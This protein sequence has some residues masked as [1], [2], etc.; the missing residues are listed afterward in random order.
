MSKLTF[1]ADDELV[2]RLEAEFD[3]SKSQVL[4]EALQEYIDRHGE[5]VGRAG[6]ADPGSERLDDLLAERVDR[7]VAERVDAHG[8]AQDINV[9]ISVDG[10]AAES[11]TAESHTEAA[12]PREETPT[13]TDTRSTPQTGGGDESACSQCGEPLSE[14]H[15]YCPN[16]GEKS[17]HRVF[18]EC[19]DELRSDWAYCP[20][21]G[22]RTPAADVLDGQ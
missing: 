13:S 8:G 6:R 22:R 11:Q 12:S 9:N 19:G 3:A 4:R 1:R 5:P 15:V 2:A 10:V 16:C 20:G 17:S 18:C 21:C 7:L 14:S